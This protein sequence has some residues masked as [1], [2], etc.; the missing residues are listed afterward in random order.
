[1]TVIWQDQSSYSRD[2]KERIPNVW[3]AR[4]NGLKISVVYNHIYYPDRWVVTC[5]PFFDTELLKNISMEDARN[6]A[7]IK[8]RICLED[9]LKGLR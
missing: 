3:V 1:M 8:V 9:A 2:N 7:L 5:N 6:E 4:T